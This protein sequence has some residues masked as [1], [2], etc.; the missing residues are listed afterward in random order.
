MLEGK[1]E[2]DYEEKKKPIKNTKIQH[3]KRSNL[4]KELIRR[5]AELEKLKE[6]WIGKLNE[7]LLKL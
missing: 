6:K 1:K 4:K 5:K 3:S 2:D 7:S